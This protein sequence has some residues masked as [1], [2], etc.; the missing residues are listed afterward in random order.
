[1]AQLRGSMN[2]IQHPIYELVY[3]LDLVSNYSAY[4]SVRDSILNIE[5]NYKIKHSVRYKSNKIIKVRIK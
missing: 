1:M 3:N 5:V 4:S 2:K